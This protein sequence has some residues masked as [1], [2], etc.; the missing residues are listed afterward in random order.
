M[1]TSKTNA[2]PVL[3]LYNWIEIRNFIGNIW[4]LFYIFCYHN[5]DMLTTN[6]NDKLQIIHSELISEI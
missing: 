5:E 4:I 2:N 1:S 3:P 6:V